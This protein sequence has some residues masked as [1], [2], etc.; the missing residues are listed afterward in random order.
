MLESGFEIKLAAT[1]LVAT[2]FV[3][4]LLILA[5]LWKNMLPMTFIEGTFAFVASPV[6]VILSFIWWPFEWMWDG[7]LKNRGPL[8]LLPRYKLIYAN[9]VLDGEFGKEEPMTHT[10]PPP[11]AASP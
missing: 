6:I 10:P 1:Y 4:H 3:I 9:K 5:V 11:P 8:S 2:Y 7:R